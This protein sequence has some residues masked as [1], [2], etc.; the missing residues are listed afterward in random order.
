[1][2]EGQSSHLQRG[3]F[4][5]DTAAHTLSLVSRRPLCK[6]M[7]KGLPSPCQCLAL[8]PLTS[9]CWVF[10]VP[11]PL[12]RTEVPVAPPPIHPWTL[13]LMAISL[14]PWHVQRQLGRVEGGAGDK[15]RGPPYHLP[16]LLLPTLGSLT[17]LAP[18]RP[19]LKPH[20]KGAHPPALWGVLPKYVSSRVHTHAASDYPRP[21]GERPKPPPGSQ[22]PPPAT[23]VDGDPPITRERLM[24]PSTPRTSPPPQPLHLRFL[25]PGT[26]FL[27][28]STCGSPA[29]ASF[30]QHPWMLCRLPQSPG[31]GAPTFP[32]TPLCTPWRSD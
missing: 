7:G 23:T 32:P 9:T 25:L 26:L 8:C 1:M 6:P 15:H 16:T 18:C 11:G 13:Q 12:W 5:T 28:S 10:L 27:S 31:G 19:S 20:W 24:P 3:A 14:A 22:S 4:F 29:L 30:I 17:L 2:R 21:S